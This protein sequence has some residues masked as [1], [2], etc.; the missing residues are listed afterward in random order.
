MNQRIIVEGSNWKATVNVD[1]ELCGNVNFEAATKALEV[2]FGR[3]DDNVDGV[4][5]T[6]N[7]GD[8]EPTV[9]F[10]LKIYNE[11]DEKNDDK[12]LFVLTRKIAENAGLAWMAEQLK[13]VEP[14]EGE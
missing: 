8:E 7:N 12:H 2:I 11:G 6:F 9:G 13:A 5:I 10:I 14:K 4:E 1:P 3:G